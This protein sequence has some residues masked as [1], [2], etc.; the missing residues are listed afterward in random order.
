LLRLDVTRRDQFPQRRIDRLG[1]MEDSGNVRFQSHEHAPILD[2]PHAI[3]FANGGK[4]ILR[5]QVIFRI[6]VLVINNLVCMWPKGYSVLAET[7]TRKP[8]VR[9]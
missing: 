4:V 7:T 6:E 9:R 3:C 5:S 8:A 1:V 2:A